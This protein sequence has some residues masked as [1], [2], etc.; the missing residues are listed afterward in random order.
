MKSQKY[1]AAA[2]SIIEAIAA[3]KM[4][5]AQARAAWFEACEAEPAIRTIANKYRTKAQIVARLCDL[6]AWLMDFP[7][8]AAIH[9]ERW[10]LTRNLILQRISKQRPRMGMS[11]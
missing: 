5:I 10:K 6:V 1:I 4:T 8:G 9:A 7:E 2:K 3:N 11:C